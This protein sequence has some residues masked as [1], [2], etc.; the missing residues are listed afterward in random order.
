MRLAISATK[1]RSAAGHSFVVAAFVEQPTH[2]QPVISMIVPFRV[3][4]AERDKGHPLTGPH[5]LSIWT[6]TQPGTMTRHGV[7]DQLDAPRGFLR[8]SIPAHG[9]TAAS[10]KP[11]SHPP[12]DVE[13]ASRQRL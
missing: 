7:E 9:D 6:S 10:A 13:V 4:C 8:P 5:R 12:G 3:C 11:S 2:C 1:L